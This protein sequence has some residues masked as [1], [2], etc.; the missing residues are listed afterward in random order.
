MGTISRASF[1]LGHEPKD[2]EF[3]ISKR[4]SFANEARSKKRQEIIS[5][6]RKALHEYT[7][8][9][10][11]AYTPSDWQYINANRALR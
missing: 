4:T 2:P 7:K 11:E 3:F 5:K 8:R 9:N 6:K 1:F 10:I